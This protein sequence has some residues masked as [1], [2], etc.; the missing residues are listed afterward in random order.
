MN[1]SYVKWVTVERCAELTGYSA[2]AIRHKIETGLW[3]AG[4]QW[5]WADDG[6]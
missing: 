3:A 5:K 2:K 1:I 6:S 4:E